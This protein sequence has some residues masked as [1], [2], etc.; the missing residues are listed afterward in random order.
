MQPQYLYGTLQLDTCW[1]GIFKPKSA[2]MQPEINK[3]YVTF[4]SGIFVSVVTFFSI[5][6]YI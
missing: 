5:K 6:M 3:T 4:W 1:L 2:F